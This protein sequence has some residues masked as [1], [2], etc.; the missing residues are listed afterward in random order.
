MTPEEKSKNALERWH[1]RYNEQHKIIND[2]LYKFCNKH[3][4]CFPEE[5]EWVLCNEEYFYINKSNSTDGLCPR[6]KRCEIKR[7]VEREYIYADKRKEYQLKRYYE[8]PKDN[9][10][11]KDASKKARLKGLSK[12]WQQNNPDKVKKYN[13]IY[14]NKKHT[15]NNREWLDCKKYFNNQCAYCGL[16]KE[17]HFITR[18]NIT[19]L[20]DFHKEHIDPNGKSD[21]GNCIPSCRKC[22]DSKHTENMEKWYKKQE[23]YSQDK[24]NKIYKWINEDYKQFYIEKKPR[25][26]RTYKNKEL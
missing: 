18:N 6:C 22:N 26:P 15:I 10:S 25:K 16:L 13:S 20:G 21:L 8:N 1:K 5:D 23:F 3:K 24:L 17:E 9:K 7:V 11:K 4:E 12:K 19:K 14:S 2:V